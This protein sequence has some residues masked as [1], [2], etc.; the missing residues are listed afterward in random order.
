ML[1]VIVFMAKLWSAGFRC[2]LPD[3]L[4]RARDGVGV[5]ELVGGQLAHACGQEG[6][7]SWR[8]H[9]CIGL[10]TNASVN[11]GPLR[12]KADGS[13]LFPLRRHSEPDGGAGDSP[14]SAGVLPACVFAG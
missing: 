7:P 11:R 3:P 8:L 1:S 9:F 5:E 4:L 13:M 6:W 14:V 12:S 2:Q 10:I